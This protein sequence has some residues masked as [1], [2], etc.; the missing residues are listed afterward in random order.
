VVVALILKACW[1]LGLKT[2]K[3]DRVA[4]IVAGV[5]FL[6]TLIFQRELTVLFIAAGLLGIVLFAPRKT[7]VEVPDRRTPQR[8][9]Y[10]ATAPS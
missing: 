4:W 1:N 10:E 6:A 8:S 3:R 9:T 7:T 5:A 2:L